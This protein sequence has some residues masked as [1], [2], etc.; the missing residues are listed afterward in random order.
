MPARSKPPCDQACATRAGPGRLEIIRQDPLTVIDVGHTPDGIRQSLASLQGDPWRG[1]LDPGDRRFA[2]QERRRD[3]RARW[4]RRSTPSSARRRITR[5]RTRKASPPRRARPIR[6]RSRS[7]RRDHRG[8]GAPQPAAGACACSERSMWPA[9]CSWRSNTR[10]SRAA[11][12]RRIWSFFDVTLIP[13]HCG[14]RSDDAAPALDRESR[15]TGSLRLTPRDRT[16]RTPARWP[17][18]AE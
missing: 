15:S 8:R 18:C 2:R 10:S 12:A 11:A 3:R 13:R 6:Q 1:R 5:A 14:E 16:A 9:D 4:R 7:D 17:R